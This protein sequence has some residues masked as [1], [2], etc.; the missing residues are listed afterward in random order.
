MYGTPASDQRTVEVTATR[1]SSSTRCASCHEFELRPT[2]LTISLTYDEQSHAI[3]D[4]ALGRDA[5]G[6]ERSAI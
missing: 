2:R 6:D 3:D 4:D 5:C 1:S